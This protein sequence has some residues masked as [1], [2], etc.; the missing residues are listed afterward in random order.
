MAV[1]SIYKDQWDT[2]LADMSKSLIGKRAEI[3]VASLDLGDQIV[4]ERLP[5]VAIGYDHKSDLI[6]IHLEGVDHLI[7]SP[8]ELYV[9][10]DVGG[11]ACLEIVDAEGA[12]QIVKMTD[13]LT[14]PDP[15]TPAS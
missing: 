1:R 13:P 5:L 4:A 14:L 8:R 7:R 2:F 9:D 11:L 6:S 12:R 15:Q 3:E 10:L